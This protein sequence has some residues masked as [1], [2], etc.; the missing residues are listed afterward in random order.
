MGR[1]EPAA[2]PLL[3]ETR[4]GEGRAVVVMVVA[5]CVSGW[6]SAPNL[7]TGVCVCFAIG[8]VTGFGRVMLG[9]LTACLKDGS[10]SL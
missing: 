1:T 3:L 8:N 9:M 10:G 7:G 5:V 4:R 6:L 2:L